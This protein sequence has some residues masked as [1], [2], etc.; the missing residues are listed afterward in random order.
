MTCQSVTVSLIVVESRQNFVSL[1]IKVND[2]IIIDDIDLFMKPSKGR[3][4]NDSYNKKREKILGILPNLACHYPYLMDDERWKFVYD[5][6]M[7]ALKSII[8]KE[9]KVYDTIDIVHKGGRGCNFDFKVSFFSQNNVAYCIDQLEFK[10]GKTPQQL[11]LQVNS[12]YG[13]FITNTETYDTYFYDN[14]LESIVDVYKTNAV[15]IPCLPTREE[16]IK[17]VK[18]VNVGVHDVFKIM[19]DNEKIVQSEKSKII[20]KSIHTYLNNLQKENINF[21]LIEEKLHVTQANKT[22]IIWY[23]KSFSIEYIK[24]DAIVLNG[25]FGLKK[26]KNGL[27]NTLVLHTKDPKKSWEFLLRWRNHKG[28]LNPAW[29]IK[30]HISK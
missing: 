13:K 18:S 17:C 11:S 29:Q 24:Q 7:S 4:N 12:E 16:Y 1:V 19:K 26:G 23:N 27:V 28:I 25:N 10:N 20:D 6:F 5:K 15:E 14:Y 30:L 9:G 22:Y 21:D 2:D 8:D 3:D